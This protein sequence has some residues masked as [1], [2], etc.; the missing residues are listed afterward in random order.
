MRPSTIP[1]RHT[2]STLPKS[3]LS[4]PPMLNPSYSLAKPIQQSRGH[5]SPTPVNQFFHGP[6][7]A[8][9]FVAIASRSFIAARRGRSLNSS[10][11]RCLWKKCAHQCRI[12]SRKAFSSA[13]RE[14]LIPSTRCAWA[15]RPC[16]SKLRPLPALSRRSSYHSPGRLNDLAAKVRFKPQ[17]PLLVSS[18][19]PKHHSAE[20]QPP[21]QRGTRTACRRSSKRIAPDPVKR[22]GAGAIPA[23]TCP[24]RKWVSG[25]LLHWMNNEP[26]RFKI[27][28]FCAGSG[29]KT[30]RPRGLLFS[31]NLHP[32][33]APCINRPRGCATWNTKLNIGSLARTADTRWRSATMPDRSVPDTVKSAIRFFLL[34]TTNWPSRKA[35][36][37][38]I[39]PVFIPSLDNHG[40]R[41]TITAG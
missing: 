21:I 27:F 38:L 37:R 14:I 33:F 6:Y 15:F 11:I 5:G 19:Q 40:D 41:Q 34:R 36:E 8:S 30:V 9:S 13:S 26:T 2:H 22:K 18:P 12:V 3:P 39:K 4:T 31:N 16:T 1:S 28:C 24:A 25:I 23:S 20:V 7:L 32:K 10:S 29:Q 17:Q 35:S